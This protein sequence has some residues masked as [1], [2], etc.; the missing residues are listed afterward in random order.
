[1]QKLSVA[2]IT[3]NEELNIRRC[4]ESVKWADEIVV[5]DSGSTDRTK[6]ICSEY[7]CICYDTPWLGFGMTKDLAV[8]KTTYDWVLSIDA[9]EVLTS[10]LV[11]E[12]RQL[13]KG[14]HIYHG[15]KIKRNSFYLGKMVRFCGW[16]H[17]YT[18]RLFNKKNGNFNHKT[19]H[20]Y[21]ELD[22]QPG[23][24]KN[25]MLHYTYPDVASHYDKMK[26]YAELGAKN[27]FQR[28]RTSTPCIAIL[29]GVLKFVK[30][31]LLQK[32]FLDGSTGFL[33]SVNSGWGVYYK[34][35]LLWEMHRSKS[36][37]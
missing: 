13:L 5:I 31:Y 8:S 36:S 17:D 6:E 4:L 2:I 1:M 35:L 37:I 23:L 16:N 34:Y 19:V 25:A 9:D 29:R 15:Y 10:E 20:E 27:L 28:N 11:N 30:M 33:L 18:L 32:G 22:S 12:I 14:N 7:K 26:R 3:K 21:V 24:L